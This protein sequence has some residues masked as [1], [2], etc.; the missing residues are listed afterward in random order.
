MIKQAFEIETED[1]EFHNIHRCT[2][3]N[4]FS[5]VVSDAQK[6][7]RKS[8]VNSEIFLPIVSIQYN[9]GKCDNE[10]GKASPMNIL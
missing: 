4:N 3:N 1:V 5:L 2:Q 6:Y 8:Q 10:N 7:Q 9:S